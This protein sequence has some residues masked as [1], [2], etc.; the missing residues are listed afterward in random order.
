MMMVDP[1]HHIVVLLACHEMDFVDHIDGMMQ[2]LENKNGYVLGNRRVTM[3]CVYV[4]G[5]KTVMV[6]YV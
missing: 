2:I 1:E 3:V 5:N 6:L 4:P